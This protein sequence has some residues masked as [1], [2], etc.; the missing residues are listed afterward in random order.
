[1]DP[2]LGPTHQPI[3]HLA[4]YRAIPNF[5]VVRPAD[6]AETAA[7]WKAILEQSHPAAIILSRQNLPNPARGEG[8]GLA[9]TEDLARGAYVL[10]DTEGTPDVI[11]LASGSEVS[12]ALEAR[13]ALAA[14]GVAARVVS[15]PCLDWFEAQDREYRDSVLPPSVRAR[16]SVEAGIALPWYRW[17]GDA[18]RAVS[19]EH[20]GASAP[21]E[22]LFKEYGI[23]AEHVA[24]AAK[25][26]IEA[27]RS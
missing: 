20:F 4:S 23:D 25:E 16:V 19:I 1:M 2:R 27:A 6:A 10:A 15:V 14:E 8:T 21:G 24:A 3:E 11:L 18:G 7:S 22:L 5:A 12:V 17:I 13:E 26:S 9:T